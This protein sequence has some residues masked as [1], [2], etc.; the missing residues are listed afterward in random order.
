MFKIFFFLIYFIYFLFLAALGLRCCAQTFSICGEWGLL[1]VVF[2]LLIAVASVVVKHR[3][4][5]GGLQQLWLAGSRVQAQQLWRTGLVAP[6]YV[7]SSRTRARTCVPCNGRQ[8][9]NH[10]ATREALNYTFL[11]NPILRKKPQ[12]KLENI[13]ELNKKWKKK[14]LSILWCS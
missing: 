10:C 14:K 8:I 6:Q 9:L 13:F 3:F 4:Q 12:G 5:A 7:G 11:N 1:F 2:R